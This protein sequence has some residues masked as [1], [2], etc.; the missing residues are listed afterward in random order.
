MLRVCVCVSK[1]H[2]PQGFPLISSVLNEIY[3]Q[4]YIFNDTT[5]DMTCFLCSLRNTSKPKNVVFILCMCNSVNLKVFV[6]SFHYPEYSC[7][8]YSP[9]NHPVVLY[10]VNWPL[11]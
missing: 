5:Q 3:H 8:V 6:D 11:M 4:Q 10:T 1:T 9:R 7:Y 2:R